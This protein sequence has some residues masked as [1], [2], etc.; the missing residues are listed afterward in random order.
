M[1]SDDYYERVICSL[2]RGHDPH[3]SRISDLKGK[4]DYLELKPKIFL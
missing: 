3:K 4:K 1:D 2:K